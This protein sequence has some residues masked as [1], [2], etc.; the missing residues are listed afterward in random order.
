MMIQEKNFPYFKSNKKREQWFSIVV[1]LGQLK[2]GLWG[3]N[4]IK[5]L[6]AYLGN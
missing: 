1:L 6:G 4:L 5:V 2:T 3:P